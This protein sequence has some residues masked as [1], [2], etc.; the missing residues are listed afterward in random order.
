MLQ[1][2]S[3]HNSLCMKTRFDLA[4]IS[5][6]ASLPTRVVPM[7]S[8]IWCFA[9]HCHGVS[10]ARWNLLVASWAQ[11]L[12]QCFVWL[13]TTRINLAVQVF[14]NITSHGDYPRK[15]HA[16]STTE[17]QRAIPT[18]HTSLL[19]ATCLRVGLNPIRS[20]SLHNRRSAR[21]LGE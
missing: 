21:T 2:C 3:V 18:N 4:S 14:P 11:I 19:R 17:T 1:L 5:T 12:F 15:A 9:W 16:T 13:N 20:V 8:Q 10:H 7:A 6:A